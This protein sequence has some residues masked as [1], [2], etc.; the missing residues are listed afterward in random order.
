MCLEEQALCL[1]SPGGPGPGSWGRS[2]DR[3]DLDLEQLLKTGQARPGPRG[4]PRRNHL[5]PPGVHT[6][7][8]RDRTRA[9]FLCSSPRL[10]FY[11]PG[12]DCFV[13]I[14]LAV[15]TARL[16]FAPP[17]PACC[18][19]W[20]GGGARPP[21]AAFQTK[22]NGPPGFPQLRVSMRYWP[23]CSRILPLY[24]TFIPCITLFY[25]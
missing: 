12:R 22:Q 5:T 9:P 10:V 3:P 4:R 16:L 8:H 11:F 23:L 7:S 2:P 20:T 14:N 25:K 21:P 6:S 13:R 17:P 1:L 18:V 19:A 24:F 15:F